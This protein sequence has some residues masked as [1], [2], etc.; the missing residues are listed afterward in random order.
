MKLLTRLPKRLEHF[1]LITMMIAGL[2]MAIASASISK[3]STVLAVCSG[4]YG[5]CGCCTFEVHCTGGCTDHKIC[6]AESGQCSCDQNPNFWS[7]LC[8]YNYCSSICGL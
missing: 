3:D 7:P 5:G 8:G 6:I 2:T 1:V 4:G